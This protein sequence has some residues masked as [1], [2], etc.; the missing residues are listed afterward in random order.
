MNSYKIAIH[1]SKIGSALHDSNLNSITLVL[2]D[3][4][5]IPIAEL[6]H[7]TFSESE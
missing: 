2:S 6:R 5:Q 4:I 3:L 7:T 1:D